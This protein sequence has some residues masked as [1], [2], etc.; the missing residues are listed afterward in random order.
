MYFNF[1][2]SKSFLKIA[3]SFSFAL[4]GISIL[5]F[6]LY[7]ILSYEARI[8]GSL[9]SM[10]SP[11]SND[12]LD[13][14]YGEDY[15]KAS[16]WFIGG[17]KGE[18]F[19]LPKVAFYNLSIPKLKIE[20][21]VVAIGGEDLDE[22]LIQYPGTALPGK[23]GNAVIFGHSIL[24]RFYNP[25]D[26]ISIFSLLPTLEKGDSIFVVYDGVEYLYKVEDMFEVTP[27]DIQVLEQ[28]RSD[29]YL[30][31]VTCT[32][33]GDP[34]KPKRLIVRAKIVSNQ[35]SGQSGNHNL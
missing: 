28:N 18:D 4:L 19:S 32:P 22:H 20:N 26:Y 29:S 6:T 14:F 23:V 10:L 11:V 21:A 31:L 7:P 24:P 27:N 35:S 3:L 30:T 25:K 17:A 1:T 33:P 13:I 12:D 15:M 8:R 5:G 2:L 16:N 34:R 9:S